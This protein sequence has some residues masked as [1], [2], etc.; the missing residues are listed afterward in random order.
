MPDPRAEL[1]MI[2]MTN[3]ISI[4]C[5]KHQRLSRFLRSKNSCC[6]PSQTTLSNWFLSY[7]SMYKRK[8][9]GKSVHYI[10]HRYFLYNWVYNSY[11]I[12]PKPP[13]NLVLPTYVHIKCHLLLTQQTNALY[14]VVSLRKADQV[15]REDGQVYICKFLLNPTPRDVRDM[16]QIPDNSVS[17][18]SPHCEPLRC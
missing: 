7:K 17:K 15:S 2:T 12:H 11:T 3:N 16:S 13:A 14:T 8:L 1:E 5:T 9:D 6:I 10:K 18:V 4:T